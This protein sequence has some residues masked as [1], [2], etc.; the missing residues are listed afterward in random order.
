M[1][2]DNKL[3]EIVKFHPSILFPCG[4]HDIKQND[5][6]HNDTQHNDPQHNDTQHIDT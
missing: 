1:F 6:Q 4:C 3:K 2:L 5:T